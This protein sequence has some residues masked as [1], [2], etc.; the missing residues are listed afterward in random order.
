VGVAD[1]PCTQARAALAAAHEQCLVV[2]GN[3]YG[4][5]AT[6]TP[7]D[8]LAAVNTLSRLAFDAGA[9]FTRASML[10]PPPS[11]PD[12]VSAAETLIRALRPKRKR[13]HRP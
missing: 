9:E 12:V 7:A 2:I 6:A 3:H 5:P 10:P 11:D 13:S 1:E 8:V 4:H